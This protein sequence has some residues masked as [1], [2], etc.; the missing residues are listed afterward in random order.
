[1]AAGEGSRMR[2]LTDNTPKPLLKICGKT[3]IEH[4]IESII[5][6][7]DEIYIVVQYKKHAFLDYFGSYYRG[8]LIH[9]I[10]QIETKGTGAA[11]LSLE[12]RITGPFIVVSWDDIYDAGDIL[13]LA[14]LEWYGTLCKA[15]EKPENF[16]IFSRNNEWKPI[17]IVEKPT[18]PS[19]GNFANIGIHKF[20][21]SIFSLLRNVPLSPRW[22]LEI[23]DLIHIYIEHG[24]YSVVEATGRWIPIGY[25]WDLLKVNDMIIGSYTETVDKWATIE[26]GVTIKGNVYLEEWVILK[27]G[28]YIEWNVYIGKN[29]VVWPHSYIRGNTSI[30]NESKIGPFVECKNS[31]LGDHS[32][33]PHLSYIGDSVIGNSV[34]I[35]AWSKVGNLRHD[36]APIRVMVKEKLVDTGRQKLGVIIGDW[37]RLGI[38]TSIYPGRVVPT[39]GATLPG[40]IV[41]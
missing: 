5:D 6:H 26:S 27:S 23:T 19:L 33:I 20:D 25:P 16:G 29:A 32:A 30:G 9:Y 4:N 24:S 21:S 41:K 13:K 18:N 40:E 35:W 34:N 22:E 17:G 38:N 7:F 28:T 14:R 31:Y 15:V 36:H 37:A 39:N 8:K 2:P 1:M 3:I 10:D 12:R 11:I